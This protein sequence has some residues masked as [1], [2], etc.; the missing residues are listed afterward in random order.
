MKRVL[1]GLSGLLVLVAGVALAALLAL[2]ASLPQLAGQRV[3]PA[4]AA[5]VQVT[6]DALG[7]PTLT[8]SSRLD[9]AR[10]TGFVHAQ[11]RFFQMDLLRR[12]AAGELA[13][14][15]GGAALE[16]DRQVRVHGLRAVARRAVAALSDA[17]RALLGAYV[18]GVNA[19]LDALT[20]PPPEYLL[21]RS[22]P[23]PW[24]AE[25]TVLAVHAMFLRLSD[26]LAMD[27]L[28]KGLLYECLPAPVADF[29]AAHD[30]QWAAPVDGGALEA[31][32]LPSAGVYDL[33]ALG[34]L[35]FDPGRSVVQTL[36]LDT[37]LPGGA[38]NAWVVA[39][40]RTAHGH[41]LVANDMHLALQLPNIWYRMRLVVTGTTAPIDVSGVSLP[42]TPAV[43]AG[44]NGRVAWGFT[45]A[46][47]DFSDRIRL[48]LD[49]DDPARYLT[50]DG[51]RPLRMREE[52][53]AVRGGE[54]VVMPVRETI[55]GPL[56][57]DPLQRPTALRWIGHAPEAVNLHLLDFE[58]AKDV[59]ELLDLAPRAGIPPQ[60]LTA[61]DGDGR[62]GWTIAGRLPRR[63]SHDPARPGA[64]AG[65][66]AGWL[67]GA[68][69]PRIVDPPEG[70][71]WTAN[72]P[73]VTGPALARIGDGGYWH[74]ARARQIRDRLRA[75]DAA[76]EAD[77]LRIQLDD[78]ALL[79]ARWKALLLE[80]LDRPGLVDHPRAA[81]FR[82]V[83]AA[84]DGR[85]SA[86]AADYRLVWAFRKRVRDVVFS[87]ITAPCRTLIP[88]YRF[89][90]FRQDEGPL[91]R[92]LRERPAHLLH[93]RFA[94][95]EALLGH[96]L[97]QT[98]A[99]FASGFEG[100]FAARTWGEH[101]VL[102]L[103]HPLARA[104]PAL[105]PLLDL[106]PTP[107][108]GARHVPRVLVGNDGAS[109]RFA[110]APGREQ[111]GYLH[112][113]GG[114]SGHPL[115]AY[116]RAGHEAW[117]HGQPLPFLPGPAVHTLILVP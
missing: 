116:Y 34:E 113:P 36:A 29:L 41:A 82:A 23:R 101:N 100:P 11:D 109:E 77:M 105:A 21:L 16:H 27:E 78:R 91:W 111:R 3:L 75:L 74:G 73:V 112:M 57:D 15:F 49:P 6:R 81:E 56:I 88:G 30:P 92:L 62:I 70:L 110:V 66:W 114:Q 65:G 8:G 37:D 94:R 44:S 7:V 38:S 48:R 93:P 67:A 51:S 102:H 54:E 31:A 17:H 26:P 20:L 80:L 84:G 40:A 45:N 1:L 10:A 24:R 33:R 60:N 50:A 79:L 76:G 32:P 47:G 52:R 61:G 68:A 9:V 106:A 115:S 35:D 85:A 107:V 19:G 104:V 87:A 83:V 96:V 28:R 12:A 22:T 42:G 97:E 59:D 5:P 55:W 103:R 46:Y 71:I 18:E 63:L 117:L 43:V 25:D 89:E 64:A 98:I 2:R 53:I 13:E 69:Y 86:A 99:H 14:L 108:S 90:G 39:G 4:L 95:W 58:R 72:H